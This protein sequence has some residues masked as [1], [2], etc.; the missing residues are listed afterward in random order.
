MVPVVDLGFGVCVLPVAHPTPT[1]PFSL[2][3]E[4]QCEARRLSAGC[5]EWI[6]CNFSTYCISI[7]IAF[8]PITSFSTLIVKSL[9]CPI[10][11]TRVFFQSDDSMGCSLVWFDSA[12]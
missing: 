9:A 11:T 3:G 8:V 2:F 4:R 12:E 5:E 10:I 1:L 7:I 6:H